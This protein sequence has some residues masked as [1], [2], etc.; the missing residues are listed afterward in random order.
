MRQKKEASVQKKVFLILRFFYID[1]IV[2]FL[3][4]R[5]GGNEE[6]IMKKN[7]R[8]FLAAGGLA[9]CCEIVNVNGAEHSDN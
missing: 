1:G 4:G 8:I 3:F 7:Y 5:K 6:A 9:A 2:D